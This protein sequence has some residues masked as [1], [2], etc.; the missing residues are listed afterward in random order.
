MQ[1]NRNPFIDDEGLICRLFPVGPCRPA[2][3][4]AVFRPRGRI[5]RRARPPFGLWGAEEGLRKS[6]AIRPVRAGVTF[7][8]VDVCRVT[9]QRRRDPGRVGG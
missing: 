6:D 4:P 5:A 9:I 1:G 8:G 3:L 7:E 2:Y